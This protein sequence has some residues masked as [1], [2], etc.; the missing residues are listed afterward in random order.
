MH[1]WLKLIYLLKDLN[2]FTISFRDDL[3]YSAQLFFVGNFMILCSLE[4]KKK[5]NQEIFLPFLLFSQVVLDMCFINV[6]MLMCWH[7]VLLFPVRKII[8]YKNEHNS[9]EAV[10]TMSGSLLLHNKILQFGH[11]HC[12]LLVY[13]CA[14]YLGTS[15]SLCFLLP[16]LA[17]ASLVEILRIREG[18]FYTY[19]L[20]T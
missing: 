6:L 15:P 19:Q 9:L 4:K 8:Y 10:A 7:F 11:Y 20:V 12:L 14:G 13:F 16:N 5:T 17:P 2:C 3:R 18:F 1:L